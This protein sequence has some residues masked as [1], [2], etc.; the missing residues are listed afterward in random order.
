MSHRV[1]TERQM[2]AALEDVWRY[3]GDFGS[4]KHWVADGENSNMTVTGE[5]IGCVRDFNLP[6]VGD[7]QHRLD[8]LDHEAHRMTYS[9][10]K[11]NPLGMASY[12]VS[13]WLTHTS[14]GCLMSWDGSFTADDGAD[15]D[16]MVEQLKGAYL[17]MSVRLDAL[18]SKP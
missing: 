3:L 6:S 12:S 15:T 17:D 18:A 2:E 5:G 4:L 16:T 11:G 10:T 1:T 14:D 9:L 7:V 8:E 13:A